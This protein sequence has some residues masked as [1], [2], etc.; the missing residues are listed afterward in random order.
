VLYFYCSIYPQ[1]TVVLSEPLNSIEF[2]AHGGSNFRI[3]LVCYLNHWS[4]S[5]VN[6]VVLLS[7]DKIP[8]VCGATLST[9]IKITSL[10]V[11]MLGGVPVPTA[12]RVLGLRREE[13]PPAMEV[14]CEYIK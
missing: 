9:R 3:S 11:H 8:F 10:E 12:W 6:G 4:A 7:S 5:E 1:V 14:S 13:R 2:C